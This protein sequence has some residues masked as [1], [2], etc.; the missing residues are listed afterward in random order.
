MSSYTPEQLARRDASKWTL[1]QAALAPIQFIA[2]IISFALILRYFV[3]GEGYTIATISVL[4]KIGLLWAITI[5]GMI[6][7]KE[8]FGRWFLAPEFFWED[9]LN[10]VALLLH[11]LYFVARALGASDRVVM[12]VMLVAYTSYLVN[13]GQFFYRGLQARKQRLATATS[14]D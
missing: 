7:E 14:G 12:T 3:T 4:V 11:N 9:L 1:V 10:A 2:F 6:W 5:T 13:C 8:V